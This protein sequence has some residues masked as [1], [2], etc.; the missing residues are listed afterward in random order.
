MSLVL[1]YNIS[2]K[3]SIDI[4]MICH[5]LNLTNKTIEKDEYGYKLGY[6]CNKDNDDTVY[7]YNDFND[8]MLLMADLPNSTFDKFLKM[9]RQKKATVDLKAVLTQTN[10]EFTS[11][12]LY[13]EISK[14]HHAIKSGN[15]AHNQE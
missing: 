9:L 1:L 4:K 8:E 11:S 10:K 15:F 14:E 13:E 3:K 2:G 6:L 7:P 12:Q 5:K